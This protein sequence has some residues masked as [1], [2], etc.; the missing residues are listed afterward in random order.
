[1]GRNW[2]TEATAPCPSLGPPKGATWSYC[3][4]Q[5]A[6]ATS[7]RRG[8][9]ARPDRQSQQTCSLGDPDGETTPGAVCT[10]AEGAVV[11]PGGVAAATVG[12][13]GVD[14]VAY[15]LVG[16]MTFFFTC[17]GS[18]HLRLLMEVL[19]IYAHGGL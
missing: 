5:A 2:T 7:Q 13:D 12:G 8:A 18:A 17:F 9:V 4:E 11:M 14:C 16:L 19:F 15:L 1:V 10:T 3:H 6:K